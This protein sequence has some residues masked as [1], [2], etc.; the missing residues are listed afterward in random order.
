MIHPN[1]SKPFVLETDISNFAIGAMLS[2]LGK[3]KFLHLVDF[4]SCK[5]SFVEINYDIHDI[6]LNHCGAFEEWC[7]L[8]KGAQHEINVYLNHKNL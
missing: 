3:D 4:C 2:Q 6:F 1:L 8:L 5:F 7:H